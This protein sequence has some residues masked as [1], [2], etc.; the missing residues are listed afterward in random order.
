MPSWICGAIPSG[1]ESSCGRE[2]R[3]LS[4]PKPH[5]RA[6]HK[7]KKFSES[8]VPL[9]TGILSIDKRYTLRVA[10]KLHGINSI[11]N[12]EAGIAFQI[13]E[14]RISLTKNELFLVLKAERFM[15][16]E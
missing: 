1:F 15:T 16:E 9:R 14:I 4:S 6:Q 5:V 12:L 7:V 10:V 2:G 3:L 11:M 8:F 13:G